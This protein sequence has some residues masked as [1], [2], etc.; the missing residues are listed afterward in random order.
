MQDSESSDARGHQGWRHGCRLEEDVRKPYL[1]GHLSGRGRAI[2]RLVLFGQHGALLFVIET[3]GSGTE[4]VT[5]TQAVA[6]TTW[7]T[8]APNTAAVDEDNRFGARAK[9]PKTN[10]PAFVGVVGDLP[11]SLFH[12]YGRALFA[13]RFVVRAGK[14]LCIEEGGERDSVTYR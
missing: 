2:R 6:G 7:T 9:C 8:Y 4:S 10:G 12:C 3:R 14:R 13:D 5:A 11:I 1:S